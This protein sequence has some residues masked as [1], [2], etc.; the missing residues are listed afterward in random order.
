MPL[1]PP[2]TPLP[3]YQIWYFTNSFYFVIISADITL[4]YFAAQ[5]IPPLFPSKELSLIHFLN[6]KNFLPC[7]SSTSLT[8][9][10]Y[11]L[12][13]CSI[14]PPVWLQTTFSYYLSGLVCTRLIWR[15]ATR[16]HQQ[17]NFWPCSS[18]P[19]AADLFH[20]TSRSLY[21]LLFVSCHL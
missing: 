3:F 16:T 17:N 12:F 13:C 5:S 7:N 11:F 15:L 21:S 6:E 14:L 9:N 4:L 2:R 1:A 20:F 18:R 10:F 19:Y 8:I